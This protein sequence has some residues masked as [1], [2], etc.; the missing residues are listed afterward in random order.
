MIIDGFSN[1]LY[2]M[3]VIIM[4]VVIH[5]IEVG[6]IIFLKNI[7]FYDC[8]V[9]HAFSKGRPCVYLGELND[10]MYFIPLVSS[11]NKQAFIRKIYPDKGNGLKK[12]SGPNIHSLIEKPIAYYAVQGSLSANDI[13]RIFKNIK[14][15]YK[16][17]L[18]AQDEI[19]LELAYNYF[20]GE[21]YIDKDKIDINIK[22]KNSK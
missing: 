18:K 6:D 3:F 10:K 19:L 5:L 15:Y 13:K 22:N 8:K 21:K 11:E 17:V 16:V 9:D 2:N 20:N 1:L 14:S 7:C 4:K 12:V